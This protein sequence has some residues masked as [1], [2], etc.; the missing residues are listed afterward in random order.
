MGTA[1]IY[2]YLTLSALPVYGTIWIIAIA[3]ITLYLAFGTKLTNGVMI[4]LSPDLEEAGA[5]SGATRIYAL[6]KITIPLVK[7][8]LIGLWVWVVAHSI[9]ELSSALMLQGRS[10]S[11]VSTLLWSY[12]EG[13]RPTAAA[14][15]GVVLITVLLV[16][17]TIWQ[18]LS[19]RSRS[20]LGEL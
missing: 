13:G 3:H 15:V 6:R 12:W 17:V 18:L 5:T 4:Q 11:V 16:L 8:A 9:R 2:V 20:N 1:L 14:T 7:P 19:N 10:N